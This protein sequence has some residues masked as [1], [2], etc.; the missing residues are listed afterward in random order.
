MVMILKKKLK[1]NLKP[2]I[3]EE[4]II[5]TLDWYALA[6]NQTFE[7]LPDFI[8]SVRKEFPGYEVNKNKKFGTWEDHMKSNKP[9][10]ING[11]IAG[12]LISY[13]AFHATSNQY[14]Y[15]C[16]QAGV[17]RNCFYKAVMDTPVSLD[18]I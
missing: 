11:I 6:R 3:T 15:S 2:I 12:V 10:Y 5:E 8:V 18:E 13:A 17:V 4:K 9:L 14:G 7:T 1:N 16:N